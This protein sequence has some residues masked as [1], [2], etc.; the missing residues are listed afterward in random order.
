M[1]KFD[2]VFTKL[3]TEAGQNPP[4]SPPKDDEKDAAAPDSV[5]SGED[6][7]KDDQAQLDQLENLDGENEEDEKVYPEELELA[8]LA[9][10][11]LYFNAESKDLHQF[12]MK[13]AP[14][15]VI[16]FELITD[17]FEETKDWKH[18]LGFLEYIMDK[19]E[20]ISSRWSEQPHIRGKT[21]LQ[22][23][24]KFNKTLEEDQKLDNGKRLYWVRL[25]LNAFLRGNPDFNLNTSDVNED[26]IVEVFRLL[27][28]SFGTSTRGLRPGIDL[29]SPGNF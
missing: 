22:K 19:Y 29:R 7:G 6:S 12:K 11:A 13:I 25:I 16:P 15:K 1:K 20:G 4:P 8:K 27:K 17:Y 26:N 28:Q 14:E 24:D 3:I 9:V 23:I 10:R 5:P 21:I 2:D 18:V